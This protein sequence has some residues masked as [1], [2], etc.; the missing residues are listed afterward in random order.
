MQEFAGCTAVFVGK[1]LIVRKAG[2]YVA[3]EI[4][5][6][7]EF[8]GPIGV[9]ADSVDVRVIKAWKGVCS[10]TV[11]SVITPITGQVPFEV[12][13]RYLIYGH[14]D[15]SRTS[16][17][18]DTSSRTRRLEDAREDLRVLGRAISGK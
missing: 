13:K 8:N 5:D 10:D 15:L 9:Q 7:P 18:A 4:V 17:V 6:S 11:V 3:M 16:V 1:V 14:W 2:A 12:G